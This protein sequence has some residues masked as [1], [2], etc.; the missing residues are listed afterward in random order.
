MPKKPHFAFKQDNQILVNRLITEVVIFPISV[1][2]SLKSVTAKALWDTGATGSVITPKVSKAL[3]LVPINRRIVTGVNN[4]SM[5]DVVR[6]SVGLPNKVMIKSV[7]VSVCKLTEDIDMLIGMDII[8]TG[9]LSV[10]NAGGKTLFTFAVPPFE[11]KI[12]LYEKA[13]AINKRNK[14]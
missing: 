10:S 12:D 5:V 2:S 11:N 7:S 14:A 3:F 8:L 9:D 1:S 4:T 6:I 13:L